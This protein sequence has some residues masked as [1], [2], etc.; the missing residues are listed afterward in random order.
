MKNDRNDGLDKLQTEV[1]S[2]NERRS[3]NMQR[4]GQY[5]S[6]KR[7][8]FDTQADI[9]NTKT[10]LPSQNG[11]LFL[12]SFKPK[13]KRLHKKHT[14]KVS[15]DSIIDNRDVFNQKSRVENQIFK[16]YSVFNFKKT[17]S[18]DHFKPSHKSSVG[19][20]TGYETMLTAY[21]KE[22]MRI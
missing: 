13:K 7:S 1:V 14:S 19:K 16:I 17:D 4:V 6:A 11:N 15:M 20:L 2:S 18:K 12:K 10:N 8:D 9:T 21:N 5:D 3:R 22:Q